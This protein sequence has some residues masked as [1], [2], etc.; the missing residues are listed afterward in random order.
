MPAPLTLLLNEN[1]VP[2]QP[3]TLFGQWLQAAVDA[4]LPEPSAMT[5]AT[6][7]L[8]GSPSARMVLL[9]GFDER[10]LVFYT[11]Y[12]SRKAAE[13]DANPKAALVLF[14]ALL[15]RQIRVE[16]TVEKISAEESDV[17]FQSRRRSSRLG[18]IASPQSAVIPG[19]HMLDDRLAELVELYADGEVPRPAHWGGYRVVPAVFEFWQGRDSRLHDRLRYRPREGGAWLIERLAP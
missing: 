17:Y 6:A 2:R 14:W 13:L 3:L 9:R 16:G 12:Q 8:D 5:L 7:A 15:H 18:A 1:D 4:R 19:R 11:N 10:G